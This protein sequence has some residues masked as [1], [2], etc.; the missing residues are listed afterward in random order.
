MKCITALASVTNIRPNE[1]V[2]SNVR[3][4]S[5]DYVKGDL[6]NMYFNTSCTP[7]SS[8][9]EISLNKNNVNAFAL[10]QYKAKTYNF[11]VQV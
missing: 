7:E 1:D 2:A 9:C 8:E 6:E 4:Y 3:I 11:D 5:W 10:K